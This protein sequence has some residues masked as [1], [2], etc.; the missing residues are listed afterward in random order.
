MLYKLDLK[1]WLL[2]TYYY[3]GYYYPSFFPAPLKALLRIKTENTQDHVAP[4]LHW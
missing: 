1:I 4:L 2:L 3:Y